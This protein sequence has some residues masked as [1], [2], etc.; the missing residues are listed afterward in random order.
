MAFLDGITV[1][2]LASVG[3]AAR[4]SRWLSDFGASVVKVGPVPAQGGVQLTPPFHAYSGHRGMERVLLDLKAPAGVDTFLRLAAGAD[5]VIESF[6]PGVAERLGVGYAAVRSVRP[7]V[8]YCST[9]GYG[10]DGPRARWAGHDLNYQGVSGYLDLTGRDG[11]GQPPVPG[12]TLADGAGGGLHAVASIL[13]ALIR[14]RSG[15]EGAYL[16]VAAADGMLALMALPVDEFLAEGTEQA[17]GRSLLTGRYA[18]YGVYRAADGWLTVAAIEPRFWANLCSMVGLEQWA[19]HQFDDAVQGR[20]RAELT[21]VLITR[22]RDEWAS[23]LGPADT[24]VAPVLSVPEVTTDAQY[25]ARGCFVTA[26]HPS[27]GEFAQVAPVLAGMDRCDHVQ[28][29]DSSV[30]DSEVVLGRA[31]LDRDAIDALVAAGVVA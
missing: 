17:P 30:T 2:D 15:G 22:T 5:V 25:R 29:K 7:S 21:A 27:H 28:A 10:Q 8:V 16:D 6:R 9:T 13:A 4:T 19:S 31:G 1:L 11:A 23:L 3:P 18:C 26:S 12:A 24:C 20:I 14:A